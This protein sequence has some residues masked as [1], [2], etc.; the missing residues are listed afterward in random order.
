MA[1][2]VDSLGPWHIGLYTEKTTTKLL[3]PTA[4]TPQPRVSISNLQLQP[5]DSKGFIFHS[6]AGWPSVALVH[7]WECWDKS[8]FYQNIVVLLPFTTPPLWWTIILCHN[9]ENEGCYGTLLFCLNE[10]LFW[11]SGL[12]KHISSV[13]LSQMWSKIALSSLTLFYSTASS[14]HKK[15]PQQWL[16]KAREGIHEHC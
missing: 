2:V 13:C 16:H 5:H 14:R 1:V 10:L 8:H 15:T 11:P 4:K 6:P 12:W 3:L 7:M 9:K